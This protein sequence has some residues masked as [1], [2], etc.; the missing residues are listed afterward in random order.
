VALAYWLWKER[1]DMKR[2]GALRDGLED[3]VG[4]WF[5]TYYGPWWWPFLAAFAMALIYVLAVW[6]RAK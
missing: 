1:G 4:V 2:G 6:R 3:T 5:G